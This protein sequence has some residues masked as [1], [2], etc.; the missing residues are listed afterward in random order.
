MSEK[1]FIV[2]ATESNSLFQKTLV[3]GATTLNI[4]TFGITTFG[5]T[6][7]GITTLSIKGF[8]CHSA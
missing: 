7:F 1:C 8:L 6:T 3:K 5:I 2:L 4:T